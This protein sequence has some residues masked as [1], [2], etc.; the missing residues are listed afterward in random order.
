MCSA[1]ASAVERRQASHPR[2]EGKGSYSSLRDAAVVAAAVAWVVRETFLHQE[3]SEIDLQ[4]VQQPVGW[5][6]AVAAAA[7]D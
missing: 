6:V 1:S 4:M 2:W 3:S 5:V 7:V